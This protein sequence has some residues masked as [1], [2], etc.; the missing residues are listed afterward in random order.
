MLT[1]R[2][3]YW[4]RTRMGLRE[5]TPAAVGRHTVLAGLQLMV[6]ADDIFSFGKM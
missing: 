1:T 6:A 2:I 5:V 4:G 3:L